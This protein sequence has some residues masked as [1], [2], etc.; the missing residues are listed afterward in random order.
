MLV[1][2]SEKEK[3]T[4]LQMSCYS[5]FIV[6]LYAIFQ[7]IGVDPLAGSYQ[8]RLDAERMFSTL[9]NPNYLAGLA[10]I[11][12]PILRVQSTKYIELCSL[13]LDMPLGISPVQSRGIYLFFIWLTSALM[14]YWSKS[15]LAWVIFPLYGAYVLIN[16][17]VTDT[18]DRQMVYGY[19]I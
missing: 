13:P 3:N 7:K 17:F 9:G 14:I 11:L 6:F 4:Y 18:R 2:S 5:F 15:Y 10:L 16:K 12:L 8:S 19:A 1:T